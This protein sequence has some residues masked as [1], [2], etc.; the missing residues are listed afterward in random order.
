VC[1]MNSDESRVKLKSIFNGV[2]DKLE[3]DLPDVI[4]RGSVDSTKKLSSHGTRFSAFA[5]FG[6]PNRLEER[7]SIFDGNSSAP[8]DTLSHLCPACRE[9]IIDLAKREMSQ[10]LMQEWTRNNRPYTSI[11]EN[12]TSSLPTQD[13]GPSSKIRRTSDAANQRNA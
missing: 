8:K 10:K 9:V 12:K 1:D 4:L 2:L 6:G 5:A 11:Y 7:V 3:R 13:E